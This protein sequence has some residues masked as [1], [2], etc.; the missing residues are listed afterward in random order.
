MW[1]EGA[2]RALARGQHGLIA[3]GDLLA[4]GVT[5]HEIVRRVGI[6]R[7]EQLYPGVYY[8]DSTPATWKT[9]VLAAVM[10]AGPDALA[11]HRTA[12][13]LWECDAIYGRTI[14]VTV[15]F[16]EDPDPEGIIVHR[17]RRINPGMVHDSIPITSPPKALL[18]IT[19]LV[20]D[21]VLEK[22]M[23]STIRN[24]LT[25]I[26][27]LD[28]AVGLHGGRGVGGTRR[29]R[30]VI[31]IVAADNSGSVSEIDLKHIVMDAPV[32]A[33]IQQL[34]VGL[35]DGANAYPDFV[36][37]DRMRTVEVDGFDSHS[38]PEQLQHDLRRQNQLMELGWEIRRF[39]AKE[40]RDKPDEVRD[41]IVRF[42]NRP[43]RAD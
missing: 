23:R 33:P 30:R 38:T 7:L 29:F 20:P 22:A 19:P 15:P 40:I 16:N 6:G 24:G 2:I 9:E 1:D 12:A 18:D 25:T 27:K 34:R 5:D 26:E 31:R 41:Q 21:R 35:P 8:M 32:P 13:L 36:W 37:P 42:I 11:S 10:A 3:R 4:S 28:L 43:F 14:E 39:T 17:T